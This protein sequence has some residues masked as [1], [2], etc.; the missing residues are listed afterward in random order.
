MLDD[1][2]AAIVH[3]HVTV[4]PFIHVEGLFVRNKYDMGTVKYTWENKRL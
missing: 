3:M 4:K 1:H 2:M